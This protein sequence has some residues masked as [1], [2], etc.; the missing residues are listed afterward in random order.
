MVKFVYSAG[1][2]IDDV[3]V[4]K[5]STGGLRAYVH[6]TTGS[7]AEQL[8]TTKR[9]FETS[10]FKTVATV[11][12]DRPVLEVRGFKKPSDITR[13]LMAEHMV[14]GVDK[15]QHEAGDKRSGHEKLRNATLTMAGLSYNIGD[16][17]Y[18]TYAFKKYRMEHKPL[19]LLPENMH[20]DQKMQNF[21]NAMDI[22]AGAGYAVG[23]LALTRYGHGDRSQTL[24]E[25]NAKKVKSYLAENGIE[26]PKDSMLAENSKEKKQGFFSKIDHFCKKY[27]SEVFN[28]IY[29][30]VGIFLGSAAAYRAVR[31]HTLAHANPLEVNKKLIETAKEELLDVGLGAMT[32]ASALTGLAVKERKIEPEERRH[33]LG[34]VLD[35]IEEKPLRATGLG[36]AISTAFHGASTMKK[37]K[38]GDAV[39]RNTIVGRGIFVGANVLSESLLFVSSK[40]HG[41][42]VKPD[43]SVDQTVIAATAELIHKQPEAERASLTQRLAGYMASNEVLDGKA[44]D[45]AKQLNAHVKSYQNNPWVSKQ[46]ASQPIE[47]ESMAAAPHQQVSQ[48]PSSKVT[49]VKEHHASIAAERPMHNATAA[50]AH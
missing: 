40:G 38:S 4:L 11:V 16:M 7:N 49:G 27:P 26:V 17:G 15:I 6:A 3:Q 31:A 13:V 18:M 19:H 41:E 43:K 37:Y 23:S 45:I 14:T 44:E 22:V 42:G 36:Y 34:R 33:G 50:L 25:S 20:S 10:G 8:A 28:G 32:F 24:I 29:I 5:N 46:Q 30:F 35:W 2:A 21:F 1:S 48:S 47:P 39:A 9:A 12:D